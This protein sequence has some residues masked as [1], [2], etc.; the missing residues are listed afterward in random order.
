MPLKSLQIYTNPEYQDNPL[1]VLA[2]QLV[3][4]LPPRLAKQLFPVGLM[5]VYQKL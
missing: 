3:K 5:I 4:R 1:Y 2:G